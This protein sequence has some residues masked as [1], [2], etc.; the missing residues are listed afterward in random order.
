MLDG[1]SEEKMKELKDGTKVRSILFYLALEHKDS[2]LQL[3]EPVKPI[4][5]MSAVEFIDF[6]QS[7]FGK[8]ISEIQIKDNDA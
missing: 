2:L 4:H 6:C 8:F 7:A 1:Q 3:G 5:E